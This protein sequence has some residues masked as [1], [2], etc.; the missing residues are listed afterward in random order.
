MNSNNSKFKY[1]KKVIFFNL[2]SK[3]GKKI[4]LY[5]LKLLVTYK[6]SVFRFKFC[7]MGIFGEHISDE[8][9]KSAEHKH[10]FHPNSNSSA[11]SILSNMIEHIS[12]HLM[13]KIKIFN[14]QKKKFQIFFFINFCFI[15]SKKFS[16]R[17]FFVDC[18]LP[19]F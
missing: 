6:L 18:C 17:I 8:F 14:I 13:K 2:I 7:L 11:G 15:Q 19:F 3:N 9:N 4:K 16:N 5:K 10:C 1:Q 12:S